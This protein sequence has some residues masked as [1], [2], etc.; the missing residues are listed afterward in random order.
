LE[1][2]DQIVPIIIC[3]VDKEASILRVLRVKCQTQQALFI[4]KAP[5]AFVYIKEWL[6][7]KLPILKDANTTDLFD[8]K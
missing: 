1:A 2:R 5:D 6:V 7:K 8:N 3:V 4:A